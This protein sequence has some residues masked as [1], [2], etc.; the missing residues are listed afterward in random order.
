M[1]PEELQSEEILAEDFGLEAEFDDDDDES[2]EEADISEFDDDD[3]EAYNLGEYDDD[4]DESE[5]AEDAEFIGSLVGALAGPAIKGISSLFRGRRRRRTRTYRRM[6]Q[7]TAKRGVRTAILR[8]PRGTARLRLPTSVVSKT[9]FH[10]AV[11]RLQAADNRN[12]SRI[13]RTQKDLTRTDR[14]SSRAL[15]TA[16]SN[17]LQISRLSKRTR[18]A[19]A[20]MKT[21]A[22]SQATMN[23]II[24]LMQQQQLRDRIDDHTHGAHDHDF[25]AA[26]DT[27]ASGVVGAPTAVDDDDNSMMMLLP[28]MLGQQGGDDNNMMTMMMMFAFQK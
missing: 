20:K 21:E 16:M 1:Q 17:R 11:R 2:W 5:D 22:A 10:N 8:T 12:T 19:I 14:K 3:D 9:E 6:P 15:T 26:T 4:N 25:D 28:L 18:S 7:I 27:V 13:N 23:M 24:G